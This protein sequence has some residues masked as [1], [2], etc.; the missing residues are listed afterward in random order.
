[1]LFELL[2][3]RLPFQESNFGDLVIAH[4]TKAPPSPREVNPAVSRGLEEVILKALQKKR[5]DRHASA[6]EMANALKR[7]PLTSSQH[8]A[9]RP[10]SNDFSDQT[11]TLTGGTGELVAPRLLALPRRRVGLATY[12][13]VGVVGLGVGLGSVLA[14]RG[15][16]FPKGSGQAGATRA[17]TA[18]A[19]DSV[20]MSASAPVAPA[21]APALPAEVVL[22]LTAPKGAIVSVIVDKKKRNGRLRVPAEVSVPSG[23]AVEL[24]YSFDGKT[25][26]TNLAQV[27]A[28]REFVSS[29]PKVQ[30]GNTASPTEEEAPLGNGTINPYEDAKKQAPLTRPREGSKEPS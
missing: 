30:P 4:V 6:E 7:A 21:T 25:W 8:A 14:L 24:V 20:P 15:V 19:P 5:E 3:G 23:S 9:P 18:P 10:T 1:M 29:P 27:S 16:L 17:A 22:T 2:C 12:V 28:S 26:K 13:L 11:T